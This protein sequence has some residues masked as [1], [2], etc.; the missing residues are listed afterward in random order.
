MITW[1]TSALARIGLTSE[2]ADDIVRL[3]DEQETERVVRAWQ[4][5]LAKRPP[6]DPPQPEPRQVKIMHT[7]LHIRDYAEMAREMGY[8]V[9][10]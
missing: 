3:S 10:S 4:D 9:R 7:A 8:S 5:A 6:L 1:S 2:A